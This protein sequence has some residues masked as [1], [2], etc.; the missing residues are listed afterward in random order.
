MIPEYIFNSSN[1]EF[2]LYPSLSFFST[3]KFIVVF[4]EIILLIYNFSLNVLFVAM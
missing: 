4:S 3:P 2:I 1:P